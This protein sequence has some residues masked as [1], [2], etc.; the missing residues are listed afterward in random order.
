MFVE[1]IKEAVVFGEDVFTQQISHYYVL[2]PFE[3]R[4]RD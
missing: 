2:L 4:M 1:H 3:E